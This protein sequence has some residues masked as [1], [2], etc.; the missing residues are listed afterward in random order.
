MDM[1]EEFISKAMSEATYQKKE[2]TA[3]SYYWKE[4]VMLLPQR[5]S[6]SKNPIT[7]VLKKGRN[8]QQVAGQCV[9]NF[10]KDEESPLKI[11]KPFTLRTQIWSQEDFLQFVGYG[12]IGITGEDGRICDTGD[13]LVFFAED[14]DWNVIRVFI[15][16][17]MGADPGKR[18]EAMRFASKM[19][20][21]M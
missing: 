19:V 7:N 4:G 5:L 9:G 21:N 10:K 20:E 11:C 1:N 17:G 18:D 6:I 13:L 15:F 2:G 14:D 16:V 8:L 12:T 3:S